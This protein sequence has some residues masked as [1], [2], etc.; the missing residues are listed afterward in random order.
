MNIFPK[1]QELLDAFEEAQAFGKVRVYIDE[2]KYPKSFM[3]YAKSQ[4]K[5]DAALRAH[6]IPSLAS[7][8]IK[9]THKQKLVLRFRPK[10][11]A[12]S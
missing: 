9:R 2:K 4:A 8:E 12:F 1:E 6:E 11:E 10:A 3:V 5:I 7:K